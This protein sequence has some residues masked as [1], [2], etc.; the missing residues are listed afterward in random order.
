MVQC[1]VE[2]GDV[3]DRGPRA[4]VAGTQPAGERFA[5]RVQIRDKWMEPETTF[6]RRRRALLIG[7]RID[8]SRVKVDDIE[9]R[10]RASRPRLRPRNRSSLRDPV[11]TRVVDGFERAPRG[12]QRRHLPE[13]RRLIP[14]HR[15][16]GDRLAAISEHHRQIDQHPTTVMATTAPFCRRHRHRQRL[17]QPHRV[18]DISQQ[19]R[20]R[21]IHHTTPTDGHRKPRPTV[22]VLHLE[23]AFLVLATTPSTSAV[24]LT[25]RAFSRTR[26]ITQEP[27]PKGLG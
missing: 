1:V 18:R 2:H 8:Q 9:P 22:I 26:P 12:R 4:G 21:M 17:S 23:S 25:R 16:I 3:I 24:S 6:I 15:D 27:L 10:I 11:Q 13:Q 7:M 5:G 20:P 14:Q 19:P